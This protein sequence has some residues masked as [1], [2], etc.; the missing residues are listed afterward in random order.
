MIVCNG[1][2]QSLTPIF[3]PE[4]LSGQQIRSFAGWPRWLRLVPLKRSW[5]RRP[6]GTEL[7]LIGRKAR[8]AWLLLLEKHERDECGNRR[9][10]KPVP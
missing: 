10:A 8:A 6:A 3:A 5:I 7:V 9:A 2:K 1:V 4:N